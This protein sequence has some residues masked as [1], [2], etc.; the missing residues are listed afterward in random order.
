MTKRAGEAE[1]A[2]RHQSFENRET[3]WTESSGHLTAEIIHFRR[4]ACHLTF[5]SHPTQMRDH[6]S[7]LMKPSQGSRTGFW[8]ALTLLHD[9]TLG[10]SAGGIL[11]A[12]RG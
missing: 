2:Y 11:L 6:G 3:G 12:E 1:Q 7:A 5:L 9:C 8:T 4:T 10:Q